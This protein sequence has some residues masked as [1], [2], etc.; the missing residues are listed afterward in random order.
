MPIKRSADGQVATRFTQGKLKPV[1][2]R[3]ERRTPWSRRAK[4]LAPVHEFFPTRM[5]QP[6]PPA[7]AIQGNWAVEGVR[8]RSGPRWTAPVCPHS[9]ATRIVVRVGERRSAAKRAAV[10][11]GLVLLL[12]ACGSSTAEMN[13]GTAK[14]DIGRAYGTLFNFTNKSVPAKT[15]VIENGSSLEKALSQ[16]LGSSL[17]KSATGARVDRVQ[18]LARSACSQVPL[19]SPCAKVSYDI[20]GSSNKPLFSTPSTGYA[21]FLSGK[22]LVAKSTI[23]GLLGLF[24]STSGQS[25]SPPGC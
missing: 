11:L 18:L 9:S 4:T 21:V 8:E 13:P 17:A 15:S 19:A 3:A 2:G 7:P 25:G 20:L 6:G 5:A 24:Y 23:C 22:W 1:R 16:A 10:G 14:T 12:A